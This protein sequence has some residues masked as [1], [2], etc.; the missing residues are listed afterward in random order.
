MRRALAILIIAPVVFLGCRKGPSNDELETQLQT[1]LDSSFEKGLFEL[2]SFS[3][4]GHYPYSVDEDQRPH[5]LIYYDAELEFLRDHTLS[6]WDQLNVGSLIDLLG[7]TPLGVKG[8]KADGNSA[9][10]LLAVHG[11][12]AFAQENAGWKV[13][14][15]TPSGAKR[16]QPA[17]SDKRDLPY[18]QKLEQISEL[19]EQLQSKSDGTDLRELTAELE[20]VRA[21]AERRLG[22]REGLLTIS[23]GSETGEYYRQ[24]SRL[25]KVLTENGVE[26]RAYS[27]GGSIENCE[28][29]DSREVMFAYAQ[30]DIA[31][32]AY[33]GTGLFKKQLP[34]RHLRALCTLYPEAVQV[35]TLRKSGINSIADLRGKRVDVGVDGSGSRINAIEILEAAGLGLGDLGQARGSE[36]RAALAALGVGE[37]DAVF[38]TSAFPTPVVRNLAEETEISILPLGEELMG[39]LVERSPF[40][41]SLQLPERTYSGMTEAVATVGVTATLLTH[42]RTADARVEGLLEQLYSNVGLLSEGS[43]NAYLISL[44][45]ARTGLSIP[46]HPAAE[47]FLERRS[48]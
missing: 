43:P 12:I 17:P 26:A 7:A 3:R 36:P 20:R 25:A 1:R 38:L 30:N 21:S 46:L 29:V 5:V 14:H 41:I 13:S 6:D 2:E 24:G 48:R 4:R 37:L 47:R 45:R 18:R 9:G 35:V 11:S 33:S 44:K 15:Y 31:H 28:L 23:T 16:S 32:M 27:S 42:E 19:G 10:D 34:L 39:R 40:L 8:V 22:R